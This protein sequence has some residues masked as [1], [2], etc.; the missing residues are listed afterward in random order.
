MIPIFPWLFSY[1]EIH[2]RFHLLV[3][4]YYRRLPEIISDAPLRI[5]CKRGQLPVLLIV[6]DAHLFPVSIDGIRVEISAGNERRMHSFS[7]GEQIAVPYWARSFECPVQEFKPDS[8]LNLTVLIEYTARNRKYMSI[9]DNYPGIKPEPYRCFYASAGLPYPPGWF[10]GEPHYHSNFTSDQ[11]EFG[12]DIANTVKLARA[13]DLKWLFITDHSYDLDDSPITYLQ[14]DTSLPKWHLMKKETAQHDNASFRVIPAEEVSMGNLKGRNIHVLAV[15]H[16]HF[17][18]GSGD[19][20]EKWFR[21]RPDHS[22]SEIKELH[23]ADNLFMAA[24][25]FEEIPLLQ[26]ITLRR[27]NWHSGDLLESGIRHLQIINS[28]DLFQLEKNILQWSRLLLQGYKFL[29]IAGN[30]AH[31]NFNLMRQVR[32]PFVKL[33][34]SRNQCFGQMHTVFSHS[35]NEPVRALKKGKI[36]V[37]NGPFLNFWLETAGTIVEIG[38]MTTAKNAFLHYDQRSTEEFGKQRRIELI[39]GEQMIG[40]ERVLTDLRNGMEIN[41]PHEGYCRM[42]MVTE[43]G[44]I[45]LTNPIW[46]HRK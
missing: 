20:A 23:R 34:S 43:K 28:A 33:Y 5:T 6:K 1:A 12:A 11:V 44:G 40:R 3:P 7:I 36:I 22:V 24:H 14:Q 39:L 19:S 10:A 17:L 13:L 29:I 21:N 37:S 31:G 8:E 35:E 38:Q 15:N 25:P 18:P 16:D 26:R 41:L 2:Y 45:V 9:N 30:D 32:I 27:G 4:L 42:K 46:I